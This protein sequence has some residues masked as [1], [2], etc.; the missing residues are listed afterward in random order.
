[1][2]PLLA[3]LEHNEVWVIETINN[4]VTSTN[5]DSNDKIIPDQSIQLDMNHIHVKR[6]YADV[7]YNYHFKFGILIFLLK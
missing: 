7:N 5:R 3:H 2:R 6:R 1:M 4:T